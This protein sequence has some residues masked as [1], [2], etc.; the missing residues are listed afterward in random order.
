MRRPDSLLIEAARGMQGAGQAHFDWLL[1][2]FVQ[3]VAVFVWWP[4]DRLGE[5]LLTGDSPDTLLA[6][7]L[8][9][10]ATVAWYAARCGAEELLLPGQRGL[11]QWAADSALPVAR[12]LRDYL[13]AHLLQTLALLALSLPLV[14]C[15]FAVSGGEWPALGWCFGAVLFQATFFRLCGASLHL[16]IGQHGALALVAVRAV[17]VLTY[18]LSAWLLP[19]ASHLIVSRHL[20]D[21]GTAAAALPFAALFT[22]ACAG[23]LALLHRQLAR[24]RAAQGA[25]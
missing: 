11:R 14:L 25:A 10:G 5:V 17:V 13:A 23:L 16:A 22:A 1:Y 21:G 8:A 6:A 9:C 18:V 2:L 24:T 19:A 4:K 20:L 12:I 7:V 3:A 15:T